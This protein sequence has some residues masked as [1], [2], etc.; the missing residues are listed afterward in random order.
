MDIISE[1]ID[2]KIE[3]VLYD[4]DGHVM[5][6]LP[7]FKNKDGTKEFDVPESILTTIARQDKG[8]EVR[9]LEIKDAQ[10]KVNNYKAFGEWEDPR[11]EP[12]T[13]LLPKLHS[14]VIT[15]D[16]VRPLQKLFK[17]VNMN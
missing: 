5:M 7:S 8:K 16:D 9:P 4:D 10:K 12:F 3:A 1:K 6:V 2:G 14:V 15:D 13:P 11:E 17:W